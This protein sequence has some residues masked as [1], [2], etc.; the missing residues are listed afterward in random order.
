MTEPEY[1]LR[2]EDEVGFGVA[3]FVGFS[4]GGL[5]GCGAVEDMV[6]KEEGLLDGSS[7]MPFGEMG[8]GVP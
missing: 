7:V 6:G 5:L 3:V 2:E 4:V 1:K 8:G